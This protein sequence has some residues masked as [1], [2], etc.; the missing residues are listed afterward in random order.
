MIG[1]SD[2][3]GVFG[4]SELCA[5]LVMVEMR[6]VFEMCVVPK[7]FKMRVAFV[8]FGMFG[9]SVLCEIV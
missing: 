8:V 7:M 9:A 4:M 1:R 5:M 6:E 3:S 2:K